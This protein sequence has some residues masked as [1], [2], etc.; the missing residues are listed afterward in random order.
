MHPLDELIT[1]Y[2]QH[3][4]DNPG[5]EVCPRITLPAADWKRIFDAMPRELRFVRAEELDHVHFYFH[6]TV[7][8]MGE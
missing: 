1:R 4:R 6:G 2:R 5:N 7:W 8:L 3:R